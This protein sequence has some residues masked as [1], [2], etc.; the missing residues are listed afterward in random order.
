MTTA[1][2][3]AALGGD[4]D[5]GPWAQ[6]SDTDQIWF[7]NAAGD[8]LCLNAIEVAP[9]INAWPALVELVRAAEGAYRNPFDLDA[10]R[11]ALAAL[12]AATRDGS[13]AR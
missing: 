9:I 7:M 13:D 6:D 1:D 2:R 11:A 3:L 4:F 10:L 8:S 12:D 5:L